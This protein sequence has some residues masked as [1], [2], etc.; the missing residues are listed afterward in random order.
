MSIDVHSVED[1]RQALDDML[2]S[3][4]W[5]V[6][7]QMVHEQYGPEAF[8]RAVDGLLK[9]VKPAELGDAESV[10]VPQIRAAFRTARLVL[11]LPLTKLRALESKDKPVTRM[12]DKFRRT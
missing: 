7:R 11:E 6:F 8:E 5:Q 9:G 10:G 3:D 4:G 2:K 1:Q 12:F